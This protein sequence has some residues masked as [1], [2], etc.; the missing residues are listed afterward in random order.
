MASSE[1]RTYYSRYLG[2]SIPV[3]TDRMVA[4]RVALR[5]SKDSPA[6]LSRARLVAKAAALDPALV[7]PLILSKLKQFIK[8]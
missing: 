4:A 2:I 3:W 5:A 8:R 1:I 6:G 7:L